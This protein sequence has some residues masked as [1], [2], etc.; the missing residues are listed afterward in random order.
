MT[1]VMVL[2]LERRI[3]V[4]LITRMTMRMILMEVATVMTLLILR[5]IKVMVM[6]LLSMMIKMIGNMLMKYKVGQGARAHVC[7]EI[8]SAVLRCTLF[9]CSQKQQQSD[10]RQLPR[11]YGWRPR[12]TIS[13][14][15]RLHPDAQSSQDHFWLEVENKSERFSIQLCS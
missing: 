14:S 13:G 4:M 5:R 2:D 1:V 8:V 11:L 10:V 12:A 15:R 6:M 7:A 3:L 9:R